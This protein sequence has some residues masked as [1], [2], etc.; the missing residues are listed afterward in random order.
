VHFHS[1]PPRRVL[2]A[3]CLLAVVLLLSVIGYVTIEH[4]PWF[5]ALYMTIMTISTTGGE[6]RP[7]DAAGRWLTLLVIVVGFGVL[8]Y[9][10]LTLI[11]YILE[12]HLGQEFEGRR[13]RGVVRRMHDHFILCGYGRVGREIA[14]EFRNEGIPFIIIDLNSD[15]LHRAANDGFAVV[16]GDAS[17]VAVLRE[18]GVER[19]RGLVTAVD[20]DPDNI[21][22]TLSARVLQPNLFIVA[23]ANQS[24]AEPK[25]KLAGANRILSPYTI[26]GRRM[27]AL[28]MRPTAVEYVDTVLQAGNSEL[29]LEDVT[30]PAGSRWAGL[31]LGSL[32]G[33]ELQV[34]VLAIK[35]HDTM[36]FG[37]SKDTPLEPGDE[38]VAAGPRQSI[39]AMESRL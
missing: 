3:L 8:T 31:S 33:D 9:T 29:L 12:G 34:I 24:D 14:Q 2:I 23:R 38:L 16:H 7:L 18:A 4:W 25:L 19:A 35:R 39:R 22:V 37:P 32:I 36:M 5:D 26:G 1:I 15:S 13:M 27:A 20:S 6:P 28:A 11:S 17:D 21:Y 30:I 10:L